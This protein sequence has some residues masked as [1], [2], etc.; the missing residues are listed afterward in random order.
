[1]FQPASPQPR[2]PTLGGYQGQSVPGLGSRLGGGSSY[3]NRIKD[4]LGSGFDQ[5]VFSPT[6]LRNMLRQ[7]A[8][9]NYGGG[10]RR[11][12]VMAQLL[13]LDPSSARALLQ[14]GEIS[15]THDLTGALNDAELQG[16]GGYQQYL[17]QLLGGERGF[18]QQKQ[19]AAMQAKAQR[20]AQHQGFLGGLG[21][22]IGGFLP[23]LGPLLGGGG[24]GMHPGWGGDPWAPVPRG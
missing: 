13:G 15:G 21:G 22:I 18:E 24:S 20:D 16:Y 2:L 8:I 7:H 5:G 9:S 19:I 10:Q 23:G 11:Q 3:G 6:Y 12:Q 1:M 17:Q 14:Q 4:L